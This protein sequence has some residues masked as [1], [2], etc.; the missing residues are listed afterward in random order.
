MSRTTRLWLLVAPAAVVIGAAASALMYFSEHQDVPR[1]QAVLTALI[2]R[3]VHHRRPDRAHEAAAEPHRAPDDR[4]RVRLVRERGAHGLERVAA[5]DH[6]PLAERGSGRLPGSP[7]DRLP[8]R[9]AAVAVGA[10][11]RRDRLRVRHGR[12]FRV[13]PGR[14]GSVRVRARVSGQRVPRG[15]QRDG[16]VVRRL[17]DSAARGRL[18][19]RRRRDARRP[20]AP[21]EPRGTACPCA[22]PAGGRG[23]DVPLRAERRRPAVLGDSCRWPPAGQPRSR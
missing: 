2:G 18:S 21:F 5:L 1:L 6:R 9:S 10:R 19:P 22:H 11:P 14:R 17:V 3:L 7:A 4:R 13:H 16:A 23:N 15:G 20:L 12:T 8:E